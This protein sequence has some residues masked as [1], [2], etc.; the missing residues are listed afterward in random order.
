M[1]AKMNTTKLW[2]IPYNDFV[3]L[4][5]PSFTAV[6]EAEDLDAILARTHLIVLTDNGIYYRT[7]SPGK[8]S[9]DFIAWDNE[10]KDLLT[11]SQHA[12]FKSYKMNPQGHQL[13]PPSM[14]IPHGRRRLSDF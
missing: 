10:P 6:E 8:G 5:M 12:I 1:F 14:R 9:V 13:P 2:E 7:A 4:I 3:R 11:P